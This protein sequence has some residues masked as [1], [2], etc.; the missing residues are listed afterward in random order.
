MYDIST[1][2]NQQV[3]AHDAPIKC[4]AY[5]DMPNGSG[6]NG[7]LVTAG[8]DKKLKVRSPRTTVWRWTNI[9]TGIVEVQTLSCRSI[10][11]SGLTR[12]TLRINYW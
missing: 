1:G 5:I 3:A 7:V 12:W 9:S 4:L 11:P 6:Q 8:W 10:Y 2:Q